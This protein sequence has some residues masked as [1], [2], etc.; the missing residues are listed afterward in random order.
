MGQVVGHSR[1]AGHQSR[2]SRFDRSAGLD[3]RGWRCRTLGHQ[4]RVSRKL[5]IR[6]SGHPD[7][8]VC[9]TDNVA[10]RV[11]RTR[12]AR[13]LVPEGMV[14]GI[15]RPGSSPGS[16][17]G[18]GNRVLHSRT[19]GLEPARVGRPRFRRTAAAG[20]EGGSPRPEPGESSYL[21]S[22]IGRVATGVGAPCC[23]KSEPWDSTGGHPDWVGDP[24]RNPP[25]VSKNGSR[26]HSTQTLPATSFVFLESH[27]LGLVGRAWV[28]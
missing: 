22:G 6:E 13:V 15:K 27:R 14:R 19:A 7:T 11:N 4:I 3:R 12:A 26:K 10:T 2:D 1:T 20:V 23:P 28:R 9:R 8:Q 24:T 21:V 25:K 17:S 16:G 18:S 5:D